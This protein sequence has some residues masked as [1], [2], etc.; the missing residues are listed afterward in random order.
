MS[1]NDLFERSTDGQSYSAPC[2]T[3]CVFAPESVE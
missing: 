3:N 2:G 1:H